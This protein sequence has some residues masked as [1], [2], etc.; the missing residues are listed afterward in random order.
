MKQLN[1]LAF[2][3]L[4]SLSLYLPI[5][6]EINPAIQG[7]PIRNISS[8]TPNYVEDTLQTK[9]SEINTETSNGWQV[10][11]DENFEGI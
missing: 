1:S 11:L 9:S 10:I 8:I 2:F 7:S 6:D 5:R 4:L 3:A